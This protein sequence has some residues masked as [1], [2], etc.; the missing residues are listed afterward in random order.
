ML[1]RGAGRIDLTKAGTPGL[2]LDNPSLSA[3]EV[4]AGPGQGLHDQGDRR[5]RRRLDVDGHA[6]RRRPAGRTSTSRRAPA[7]SSVPANGSA[8]LRRARRRR[9]GAARGSYEGKVVLTNGATGRVLHVPGLAPRARHDAGRGRPARRRRRLVRR[10]GLPRLLAGLQ[11]HVQ[12][13]GRHATST[14]TC[15]THGFPSLLDLYRYKAVVIFT[16]N[17]DSFDTSGFSPSDQN[18]L[19]EWLDSG[20]KLWTIG[21][22][23]AEASDSNAELLV[24]EPR[25]VAAVP[26]LPRRE[27]PVRQRV[28]RPAG[29][30]PD[31]DGRDF[32]KKL[33]IDLSPGGDGAGNQSSIEVSGPM[34]DTDT[35]AASDTMTPLF[36]AKE[37][38]RQRHGH[39]VG[40][41]S[42]PGLKDGRTET[43]RQKFLYRS[44]SMGFGLEGVNSNTGYSSR[45][46]VAAAAWRWL[47]DTITFGTITATP[48]K[49]GK[50]ELVFTVPVSVVR[51]G[52]VH[53]L[54]LGL[55]RR[56]RD[57]ALGQ[58]PD[59]E[60]QVQDDAATTSSASQRP[61]TSVTRRSRRRRCTS[62]SDARSSVSPRAP[63]AHALR[64]AP[65]AGSTGSALGRDTFAG[66][67][68]GEARWPSWIRFVGRRSRWSAPR[69][70]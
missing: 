9:A 43:R 58:E 19:S 41:S 27:V 5:Q 47:S 37:H 48:R 57:R 20:G 39:R 21:Q 18:R 33:R 1:A 17:N 25:P 6:R 56:L 23:F 3:G 49:P 68:E 22:N 52:G 67:R 36:A 51:R 54:R 24:G 34:P 13:A 2:T 62:P 32:M 11:G 28:R 42:E 29:A 4:V 60:P 38:P 26:R 46:D 30:S 55:R 59:R 45:Q 65:E 35:Y 66:S 50:D 64:G 40:R 70:S 7:R 61:T 63:L 12:R 16:G 53:G 69:S 44:L 8:T 10:R 31:G 15:G 14:S